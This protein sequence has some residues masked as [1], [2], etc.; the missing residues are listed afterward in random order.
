MIWDDDEYV[1]HRSLI[2]HGCATG[3]MVASSTRRASREQLTE[4]HPSNQAGGL[5]LIDVFFSNI[6]A[7]NLS[8]LGLILVDAYS[9]CMWVRFGRSKDDVARL[10]EEWLLQMKGL[11]FNVGSVAVVRSDN[12]GEFT[13]QT[14]ISQ[15][16]SNSIMPERA[17]PYAHVNRAERAIRHVKETARA[18]VNTNR[19]NLSR[20]S[21]WKTRGRTSN[22]YIFWTDAM[23]HACAV[24]NAIP[25]K[26][27]LSEGITRYERFFGRTPDHTRLKVFGCTAYVHIPSELRKSFDETSFKVFT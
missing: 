11:K 26:K 14:F 7:H 13:S 18:Y 27:F 15:L 3:K 24:F 20:L 19:I 25:E 5:I 2:C 22:P 10:F 1:A 16:N 4:K 23:T 6:T 8:E 12:G 9:K 21:A 17:P